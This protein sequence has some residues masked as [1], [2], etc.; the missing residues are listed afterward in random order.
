M[1]GLN[2]IEVL[3]ECTTRRLEDVAG[4]GFEC[5]EKLL[6]LGEE[7]EIKLVMNCEGFENAFVEEVE[8]HWKEAEGAAEEREESFIRVFEEVRQDKSL[9]VKG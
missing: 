6:K 1:V 4:K 5:L 2:L 7:D 9:L 8:K 3:W